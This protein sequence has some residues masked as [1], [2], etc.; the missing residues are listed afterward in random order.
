MAHRRHASPHRFA[1]SSRIRSDI[2]DPRSAD[3]R[4][5]RPRVQGRAGTRSRKLRRRPRA[6][7][8]PVDQ[9]RRP[10]RRRPLGRVARRRADAAVGPRLPRVRVLVHQGLVAVLAMWASRRG[11]STSTRRSRAT[12]PSSP[13]GKGGDSRCAGCSR[14]RPGL[15]RD[16]AADAAR[17]AERLGRDDDGARRAG[18]VVGARDRARL[19]RRD[20]R[21]PRRRGAP[22]RHRPHCRRAHP[23]RAGR[24]RS[25]STCC[26][27]LPR[28]GRRAH[29]RPR[30]R[31]V[32]E[33][34]VLRP[35][36]PEDS[37]G[38]QSFGNPPDCNDPAH[39]MTETF[40][41]AEI[42]AANM[43]A[44]APRA[45]PPLRRAGVRRHA[46]TAA[47]SCARS[48]S[49]SSAACTCAATTSSWSCRPR[50]GSASSTRSPSGSSAPGP[51]TYGHN[52][53]G[54][55]LGIVDPDAGVSLGYAMNRLWWGPTRAD[56]RWPPI[57]DA[58]YGSL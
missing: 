23:R 15:P 1:R 49:T 37:L 50:S 18:A 35:L 42:P 24:V 30:R 7:R 19:P 34:H 39:C 47:G 27:P 57:F 55:S 54:G 12:G 29:R 51:H 28:A 31:H 8:V 9:R 21:A 44:N 53:S 48:W 56:P 14:T 32:A 4:H 11:S 20:V 17:L 2:C 33:R 6:R 16:R 22:P 26:M 58:L 46:S 41:A 5:H 13:A 10:Q 25:A 45:R 40:R 43:H 52:G 38:P 36:G 3:L